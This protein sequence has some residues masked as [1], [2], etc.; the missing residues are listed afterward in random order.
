MKKKSPKLPAQANLEDSINFSEIESRI[1]LKKGGVVFIGGQEITKGV[2]DLLKEQAKYLQTSQLWEI[3]NATIIDESAKLA[4][5][6]S[7]D[8]NHVLSAKMLYHWNH[9]FK[10][11]IAGLAKDD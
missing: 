8:W 10:N 3:M 2:R 4:L 11:M 9:V 6:Q 7:A 5:V 1:F